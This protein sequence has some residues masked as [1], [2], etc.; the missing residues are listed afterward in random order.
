MGPGGPDPPPVTR[1]TGGRSAP[2]SGSSA[3]RHVTPARHLTAPPGSARA[4]LPL[5]AGTAAATAAGPGRAMGRAD[6]A[7]V[8][9]VVADT[10][11]FL[12]AAPLQV[13]DTGQGGG[14]TGHGTPGGAGTPG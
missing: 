10:G 8:P 13:P 14:D 12:S 3:R 5:P 11:A 4:V 9:H 7:R 6:M 2:A 1:V